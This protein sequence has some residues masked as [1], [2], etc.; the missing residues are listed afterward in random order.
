MVPC[1]VLPVSA[2]QKEVHNPIHVRWTYSGGNEN[3][4]DVFVCDFVQL[5]LGFVIFVSASAMLIVSYRL[6]V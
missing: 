2:F 5:I 4:V 1:G 6:T 3:R